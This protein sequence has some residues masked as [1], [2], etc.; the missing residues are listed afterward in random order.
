MCKKPEAIKYLTYEKKLKNHLNLQYRCDEKGKRCI[1]GK[2]E[3]Y[4]TCN[5]VSK[6]NYK[7]WKDAYSKDKRKELE[8][9]SRG[10][11]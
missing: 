1:L 2:C 4:S 11:L 9:L 7:A 5:K 8:Q 3:K 6:M 10:G